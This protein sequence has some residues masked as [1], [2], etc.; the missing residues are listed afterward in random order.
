MVFSRRWSRRCFAFRSSSS[1]S[2]L[3]RPG[4]YACAPAPSIRPC[5][6]SLERGADQSEGPA[7][8]VAN[9]EAA[10]FAHLAGNSELL[11]SSGLCSSWEDE[12]RWR[13]GRACLGLGR[14]SGVGG[15]LACHVASLTTPGP[16]ALG[17]G[18]VPLPRHRLGYGSVRCSIASCSRSVSDTTT[19]RSPRAHCTLAPALCGE[20]SRGAL[21][22]VRLPVRVSLGLRLTVCLVFLTS[23]DSVT[24][25][26][27]ALG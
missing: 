23:G 9:H 26:D 5:S 6:A 25:R 22:D 8:S 10:I 27:G 12:V 4:L 18:S 21:G 17:A 13:C 19:S 7:R 14:A 24:R 15:G 2:L 1:S 20:G 3:L 11:L 16:S